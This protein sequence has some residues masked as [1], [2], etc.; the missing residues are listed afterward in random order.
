MVGYALAA[1]LP[2]IIAQRYLFILLRKN[3]ISRAKDW[4]YQGF[5]T[6]ALWFMTWTILLSSAVR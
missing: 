3:M 6:A 2:C 5:M 1:N 4:F